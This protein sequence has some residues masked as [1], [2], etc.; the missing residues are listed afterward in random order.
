MKEKRQYCRSQT[1]GLWLKLPLLCHRTT[2][3]TDNPSHF[4]NSLH[5]LQSTTNWKV[6]K[7]SKPIIQCIAIV[8]HNQ[9]FLWLVVTRGYQMLRQLAAAFI[10]DDDVGSSKLP[11]RLGFHRKPLVG[12]FHKRTPSD[13][14]Q[15][16]KLLLQV[17][18]QSCT[19]PIFPSVPPTSAH[20]CGGQEF[21]YVLNY[22][23]LSLPIQ[24]FKRKCTYYM[25]FPL[26]CPPPSIPST[27]PTFRL[28]LLQTKAIQHQE[29]V[30]NIPQIACGGVAATPL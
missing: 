21:T 25:L 6:V 11:K 9:G 8:Q 10:S 17:H 30:M 2:T 12:D 7:V 23:H 18:T 15:P 19:R 16:D 3:P 1:Q 4:S 28:P 26:L 29:K 20:T 13:A 5:S 27:H 24:T 14:T 22:K